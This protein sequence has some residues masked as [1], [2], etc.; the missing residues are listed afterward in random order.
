MAARIMRRILVDHARSRGAAKRGAPAHSATGRRGRRCRKRRRGRARAGCRDGEAGSH[1]R[2]AEQA[3][4]AQV[5]RRLT[6]E[7]TAAALDVAPV[8]VKRDWVLARAWLFRELR[9]GRP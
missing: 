4:G 7:E 8:T 2:E 6:V 5:L 3:R 1:R 9:A